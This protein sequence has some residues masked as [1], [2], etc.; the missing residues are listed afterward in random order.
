MFITPFHE[1][2]LKKNLF[3]TLVKMVRQTL[4]WEISTVAVLQEREIGLNF[5]YN[6]KWGFIA[7][8]QSGEWGL[9]H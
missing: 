8:D 7:E 5:K 9:V 6:K 2:V 3:M 4:F 1:V